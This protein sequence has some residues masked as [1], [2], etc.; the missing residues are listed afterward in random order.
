MRADQ[1]EI[2]EDGFATLKFEGQRFEGANLPLDF[3]D[4]IAAYQRLLREL[5]VE[6]WREKNPERA[7]LP[8]RFRDRLSLSF[9]GVSDGSAKA[10]VKRDPHLEGTL[11]CLEHDLDYLSL[12]QARFMRE[13]EAA[14]NNEKIGPLPHKMRSD[15][16]LLVSDLSESEKLKIFP[17]KNDDRLRSEVRYSKITATRMLGAVRVPETKNIAGLALVSGIDDTL[18]KVKLTTKFGVFSFPLMREQLRREFADSLNQV[19][20]FS[21]TVKTGLSGAINKVTQPTGIERLPDNSERTRLLERIDQLVGLRDGW[22]DG[23]GIALTKKVIHRARDIGRYISTAHT[24]IAAFPT[25]GGG[26]NFEFSF[27]NIE[28][29]VSV[30][31]EVILLEAFDDS[32]AEMKSQA[33]FAVTPKLLSHL[34]DLRGFL[35]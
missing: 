6:I 11:P 18:E 34:D 8:K 2:D 25:K 27:E 20:R 26:I 7:R 17:Q 22:R 3:L 16:K 21:A 32:D 9:S 29:I 12:A 19:V 31:E 35:A 24:G 5:A 15:L 10:T 28:V 13:V 14:N 4:N 30:G 33:F 1:A 23:N